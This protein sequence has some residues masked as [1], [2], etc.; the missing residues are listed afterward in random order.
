MWSSDRP[1]K[2][3]PWW[4]REGPGDQPALVE[5]DQ[6]ERSCRGFSGGRRTL[7]IGGQWAKA[8]PPPD[9]HGDTFEARVWTWLLRGNEGTAAEIAEALGADKA[10]TKRV[11]V[12]GVTAA[13]LSR[14]Y[15]GEA[16]RYCATPSG[17]TA[18]RLGLAAVKEAPCST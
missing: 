6:D 15:A 7:P 12:A 10:Q 1:A 2:A 3:G 5:V 11:L 8:T 14:R 9:D 18:Y 13:V 4:W 16:H 17:V